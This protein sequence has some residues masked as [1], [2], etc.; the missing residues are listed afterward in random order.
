MLDALPPDAVKWGYALS[1]IHAPGNS[2]R[3]LMLANGHTVMS[4][5]LVDADGADS[6]MRWLV[7]R[8]V[9]V[10]CSCGIASVEALLTLD[11]RA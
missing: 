8:G 11:R 9:P 3:D 4:D 1:S 5:V 7:S 2:E 10:S 6:L